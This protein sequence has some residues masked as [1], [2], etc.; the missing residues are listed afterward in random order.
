MS[1]TLKERNKTITRRSPQN[2]I[3]YSNNIPRYIGDNKSQS[4]SISKHQSSSRRLMRSSSRIEKGAL[5]AYAVD[6]V[7]V[8]FLF[9][10][11]SLYLLT[12]DKKI[13]NPNQDIS[14]IQ[15]A[16]MNS[17]K[18]DDGYGADLI[19]NT[20]QHFENSIENAPVCQNL[21]EHEVTFSLAIAVSSEKDLSMISHHCKRWGISAPISIA[22]WTNLSPIAVMKKI[23][24]FKYNACRSEQMT[25]VTLSPIDLLSRD[26][27]VSINQ[28][29]NLAV[30]GIQATHAIALDI[31]M[32]ESVDIYE[33]LNTPIVLREL[34]KDNQLAIVIPAFEV[35]IENHSS[36]KE[37]MQNIP[38]FFDGLIL[39]LGEKR[40]YPM[41]PFR[42]SRQGST[43][44]RSWVKQ[45]HGELIDIDCVSSNSYEPL[46]AVRYCEGLAPFQE[47]FGSSSLTSTWIIHLLHL[48]YSLKQ[49]GGA[50]V[51]DIPRNI[52]NDDTSTS[53]KIDT[54]YLRKTN[55]K[56]IRSDFFQWLDTNIPDQRQV[57]NCDD[58]ELADDETE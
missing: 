21:D 12:F 10:I 33:T 24:S 3:A 37:S 57:K 30:Q 5:H 31:H 29:Q 40:A 47:V 23:K 7:V 45:A 56:D 58:F 36:R 42:F 39:Q 9:G 44:Y 25:I 26:D 18:N 2:E 53:N 1:F 46:I 17:T 52:T 41:D 49:V 34:S 13:E 14:L 38:N 22:V 16:S 54:T 55:R 35:N 32:W 27:N 28:L 43:K 6:L 4:A 11:T 15:T 19:T 51:V 48:G 50:F 20:K 8:M